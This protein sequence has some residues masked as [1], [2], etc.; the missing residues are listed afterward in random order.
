MISIYL[1]VMH[2]DQAKFILIIREKDSDVDIDLTDGINNS[3]N[4]PLHLTVLAEDRKPSQSLE[5]YHRHADDSATPMHQIL[6]EVS[7]LEIEVELMAKLNKPAPFDNISTK[8]SV[9]FNHMSKVS[10][11]LNLS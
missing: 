2:S 4:K 6:S 3:T 11:L 8:D 7:N 1:N 10:S 9:T 5:D